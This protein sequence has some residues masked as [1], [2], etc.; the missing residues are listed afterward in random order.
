MFCLYNKFFVR[1]ILI[2]ILISSLFPQLSIF[3]VYVYWIRFFLFFIFVLS[4]FSS[5]TLFLNLFLCCFFFRQLFFR[6]LFKFSLG[7]NSY[8]LFNN[9]SGTGY[10]IICI[11]SSKHRLH[12]PSKRSF[13]FKES[14]Y[15]YIYIYKAVAS[16]LICT[17]R[18]ITQ[19]RY[20]IEPCNLTN[21]LIC[22]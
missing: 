1:E 19:K 7:I 16:V 22:L 12:L 17:S 18:L 3:F 5:F 2:L 10:I 21:T 4:Y 20:F 8:L 11:F 15:I 6:I 13:F 14:I 9:F